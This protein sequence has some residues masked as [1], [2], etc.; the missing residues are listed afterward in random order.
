MPIQVRSA[1]LADAHDAAAVLA[2]LDAYASDPRGGG[3]PLP[4]QVRAR[5]RRGLHALPTWRVWLACDDVRPVGVCVGCLG[6]CTFMGLPLLNIHDL[7][8][9]PDQRGKGAGHALLGAAQAAAQAAGCCKLTLEVQE[10]NTPARRLYQ[11]FGFRD[12]TYGNSGPTR[13]LGK[14]LG[15]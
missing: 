4:D 9:L 11:R 15:G 7:A 5:L 13:F 14:I 6:F 1:D 12:V 8:V 10:D 2:L 3:Q